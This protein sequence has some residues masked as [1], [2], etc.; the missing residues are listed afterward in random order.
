MSN[1][2]DMPVYN[3]DQNLIKTTN[4]ST[5]IDYDL[6]ISDGNFLINQIEGQSNKL[7]ELIEKADNIVSSSEE[8]A[9]SEQL[10]KIIEAFKIRREKINSVI[11]DCDNYMKASN[12]AKD[13]K[14][15]KHNM[16]KGLINRYTASCDKFKER[17][18]ELKNKLQNKLLRNAEIFL[19]RDLTEEEKNDLIEEPQKI[20]KIMNDQ[21][22]GDAPVQLQNALQN[23]EDRHQDIEKLAKDVEQITNMIQELNMM[24]VKQG[25]LIDSVA[26]NVEKTKEHTEKAGDNLREAE[27]NLKA[28][29][30]KKCICITIIV[31][32]IIIAVAIVIILAK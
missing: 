5:N 20:Q 31:V 28:A 23:L 7:E 29:C 11:E 16:F 18:M 8:E 17:E 22:V 27:K 2:S 25:T 15:L 24:V 26:V 13:S 32:V 6:R 3:T 1:S 30:R 9:L 14:Q 10:D 12:E 21:I 19:K 4:S